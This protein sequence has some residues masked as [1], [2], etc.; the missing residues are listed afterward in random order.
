MKTRICIE[1]EQRCIRKVAQI[2]AT[3]SGFYAQCPY[4]KAGIGQLFRTHVRDKPGIQSVVHR[5]SYIA[6]SRAKLSFH[7]P[8]AQSADNFL[9]HFSGDGIVSGFDEQ[10]RPKGISLKGPPDLALDDGPTFGIQ[11]WG[12]DEFHPARDRDKNRMIFA[13][14]AMYPPRNDGS[15]NSYHL[16]FFLLP[17]RLR[18][19]K[20][21]PTTFYK[22]FVFEGKLRGFDL[23]VIELPTQEHFLGVICLRRRTTIRGHSGYA[24]NSPRLH[25]W[26]IWAMYPPLFHD[27]SAKSIDYPLKSR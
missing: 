11:I 10:G 17:N 12:L 3:R 9:V 20:N 6:S 7:P 16:E 4:H 5:N 23:K 27:A 21:K 1:D 19:A 13:Q 22:E 15:Y 2:G 18:K 8:N 14:E 24:L 25:N 26:Y